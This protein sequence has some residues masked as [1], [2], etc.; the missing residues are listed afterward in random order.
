R[1]VAK[2]TVSRLYRNGDTKHLASMLEEDESKGYRIKVIATDGVFSMEGL[3]AP[4]RELVDLARRHGELLFVD[5][6]HATGA[7]GETGSGTNEE[8]CVLGEV[9]VI[10]G[11]FGKALGGASGGFIA[12]KSPLIEF[13][14]QKSRPYTFSNTMP[15]AVVAASIEAIRIIQEDASIVN[16]LH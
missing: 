10:T 9:D 5:E 1:A 11:T 2:Q 8:L 15:P 13:L 12:G 7:L 16:Q 4:L 6:S 3:L 14:R